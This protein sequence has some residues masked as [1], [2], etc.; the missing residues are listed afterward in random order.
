MSNTIFERIDSRTDFVNTWLF[1]MPEGIGKFELVDTVIY[2]IQDRIKSGAT[3][4]NLS[5]GLRKIEGSQ[6]VLYWY[7]KAG[8]IVLGAEFEKRA[9]GLVV[10]MVGKAN[11]GRP[12]FASDLYNAVL[13]DRKT[14]GGIDAIRILSDQSL[15]DEGIKIWERLL[16][17]GHHI[18][19]YDA[20]EPGKT[21]TEITTVTDLHKYFQDDNRN[22]RRWQYVI[23][24]QASNGEVRSFFNTR[25]MRELIPGML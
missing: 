20:N 24:E 2:A 9:Q 13:A 18:S 11:K 6:V 14:A 5:D 21:F 10:T 3:V 1:E 16:S 12:P 25:R 15:S 4:I 8:A 7:E 19:I 17:Q 22:Y 23:S